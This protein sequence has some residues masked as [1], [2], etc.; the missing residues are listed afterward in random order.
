MIHHT[1]TKDLADT[2][3]LVIRGQSAEVPGPLYSGVI[4]KTGVV[5]MVGWGRCNHAGLGDPEVLRDV[6]AERALS[7]PQH[8]TEDG[9]SRF[10]GFAML[11]LGDGKDPYPA[12]QLAAA[13]RVSAVICRHHG[14][15]AA[16]VIGHKDWQRGKIDPH[17]PAGYLM[18]GIRTAVGSLLRK[19]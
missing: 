11:N 2:I 14:W 7:A 12:V 4:S 5:H 3:A 13:A 17:G 9:N 1:V 16:S 15:K 18:P 6:I 10:Y 19:K 8:N